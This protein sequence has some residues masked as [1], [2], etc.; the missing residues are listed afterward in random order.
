MPSLK[1]SKLTLI[2]KNENKLEF[3]H[4]MANLHVHSSVHFFHNI[5]NI[6]RFL[7][8]IHDRRTSEKKTYYWEEVSLSHLGYMMDRANKK[9]QLILTQSHIYCFKLLR[10]WLQI[11]MLI[12]MAFVFFTFFN[13]R[14]NKFKCVRFVHFGK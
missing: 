4:I 12:V 14:I 13:N 9:N 11:H 8:Q 2:W 3:L 7:I 6:G 5:F 1:C 10:S